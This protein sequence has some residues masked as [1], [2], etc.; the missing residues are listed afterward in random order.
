MFETLVFAIAGDFPLFAEILQ[1]YT[2]NASC[3]PL[4][5][6]G[7]EPG[8]LTPQWCYRVPNLVDPGGLGLVVCYSLEQVPDHHSLLLP[9]PPLTN[10][11][12]HLI[13]IQVRGG[14]KNMQWAW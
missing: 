11:A 4:R 7:F 8:T 6:T 10:L 13:S 1:C 14:G 3:L 5:H 12:T 2:V 9:G